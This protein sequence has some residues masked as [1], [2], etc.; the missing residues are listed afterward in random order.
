M[1]HNFTK[2]P[3]LISL[4]S[5]QVEVGACTETRNPASLQ[6]VKTLIEDLGILLKVI[7]N[8]NTKLTHKL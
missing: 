4:R 1:R 5:W 6:E 3:I 7:P 8:L 2:E